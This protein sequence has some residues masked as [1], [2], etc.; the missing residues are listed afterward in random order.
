[1]EGATFAVPE[2][3]VAVDAEEEVA[4]ERRAV[5]G[6]GGALAEA[7]QRRVLRQGRP[8]LLRRAPLGRHRRRR[9]TPAPPRGT[10]PRP[11][12]TTSPGVPRGSGAVRWP[13]MESPRRRHRARCKGLAAPSWK[14]TYRRVSGVGGPAR[15]SG[16]GAP[17]PPRAG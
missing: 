9:R 16:R 3:Q 4:E 13:A 6:R 11:A 10:A 7:A 15:S 2:E 1:M 12:G 17:P 14:E 8:P 5:G